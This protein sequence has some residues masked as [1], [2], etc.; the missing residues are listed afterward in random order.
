MPDGLFYCHRI[1]FSLMFGTGKCCTGSERRYL[2]LMDHPLDS[3]TVMSSSL[4]KML[5][6]IFTVELE[7]CL[8]LTKRLN[9]II[10][11]GKSHTRYSISVVCAVKASMAKISLYIT[12]LSKVFFTLDITKPGLWL[13]NRNHQ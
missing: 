3:N 1:N 8:C 5:Q 2:S 6:L 9:I 13:Q 4:L 10:C 12:I 11:S 7:S